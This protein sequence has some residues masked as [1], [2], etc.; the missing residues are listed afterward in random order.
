MTVGSLSSINGTFIFDNIPAGQYVAYIYYHQLG[1]PLTYGNGGVTDSVAVITV[2]NG[3]NS[4][5][6]DVSPGWPNHVPGP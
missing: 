6:I 4:I 2:T 3:Y 5:N 1:L